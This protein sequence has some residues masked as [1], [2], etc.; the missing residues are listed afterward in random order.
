MT[1][2]HE[3]EFDLPMLRPEAR[4]THV[5]PE[6]HNCSLLSIGQL[7]DAGYLANFN[8]IC[9][10]IYGCLTIEDLDAT[11]CVLTGTRHTPTGMW[12]ID[13]NV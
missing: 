5:V 2:T 7:T 13:P 3:A 4:R 1:S 9:L 11:K 8:A 12:H 6:L 10:R